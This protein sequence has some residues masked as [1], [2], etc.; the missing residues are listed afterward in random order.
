MSDRLLR[1]SPQNQT[2]LEDFHEQ[3]QL[4]ILLVWNFLKPNTLILD[5]YAVVVVVNVHQ[6]NL[7]LEFIKS[8]PN[9]CE[10]WLVF[11]AKKLGKSAVIGTSR[12]LFKFIKEPGN[13]NLV[14]S[15]TF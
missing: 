8:S 11:K 6:K 14:V 15:V 13:G 2:T 9:R 4:L 10:Q 5:L 3:C 12:Q 7:K 1:L